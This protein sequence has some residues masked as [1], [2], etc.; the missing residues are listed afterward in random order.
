MFRLGATGSC[1]GYGGPLDADTLVLHPPLGSGNTSALEQFSFI[2]SDQP[3][4]YTRGYAAGE[5]EFS[6][7]GC[8]GSWVGTMTVQVGP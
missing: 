6:G 4:L 5:H 2:F 8:H 1:P 7:S 3:G